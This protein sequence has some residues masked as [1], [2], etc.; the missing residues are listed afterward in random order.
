[1]AYTSDFIETEIEG[2]RVTQVNIDSGRTK[3]TIKGNK[4]LILW[5]PMYWEDSKGKKLTT[6]PSR[7][8]LKY[9][10]FDRFV[11]W[12]A[13]HLVKKQER[14]EKR[15]EWERTKVNGYYV[16]DAPG[17]EQVADI[18]K[19]IDNDVKPILQHF[20]IKYTHIFE[21]LAES[22]GGFNKR[23]FGSDCI[24]LNCRQQ[25]DNLK[26]KKYSAIMHTMLH[27]LAHCRYRNHQ[28]EFY[29]FMNEL[30]D[31]ARKKG[32]YNPS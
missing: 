30:V 31:F 21:T 27:E 14:I 12:G 7:G 13:K 19:R 28:R 6:V 24:G 20:K 22:Y 2:I 17:K 5:D 3:A 32:I 15:K 29:E 10:T 26:I 1:M 16:Y 11:K 4:L 8:S 9:R 23:T 25:A 18:L